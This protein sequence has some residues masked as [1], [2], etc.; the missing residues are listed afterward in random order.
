MVIEGETRNRT[1]PHASYSRLL[2]AI[3]FY[4]LIF[5]FMISCLLAHNKLPQTS[6][7]KVVINIFISHSFCESGSQ[8]E[9]GRVVWLST[10]HEIVLRWQLGPQA[11]EVLAGA[12][13]LSARVAHTEGW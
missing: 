12:G 7:G 5:I 13:G 3:H 9:L 2:H 10:S 11:S 1:H 8:E 6:Q 4:P